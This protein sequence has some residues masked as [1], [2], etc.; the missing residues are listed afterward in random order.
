MGM[1]TGT[2]VKKK[3]Q[4]T[5]SISMTNLMQHMTTLKSV[6]AIAIDENLHKQGDLQWLS[7]EK[8][9]KRL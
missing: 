5:M 7:M 8:V 4:H 1:F 6:H 3:N 9:R 2:M